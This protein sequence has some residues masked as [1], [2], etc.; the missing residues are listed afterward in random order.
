MFCGPFQNRYS[1]MKAAVSNITYFSYHTRG[2][3]L[4]LGHSLMELDCFIG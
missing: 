1:I 3:V 4:D 2:V